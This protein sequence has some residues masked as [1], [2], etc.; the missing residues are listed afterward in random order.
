MK[1]IL[2]LLVLLV[3]FMSFVS[4]ELSDGLVAYYDLEESSGVAIDS[5]LGIHNGTVT[6]FTRQVDGILNNGYSDNGMDGLINITYHSDLNFTKNFSVSFWANYSVS[7]ANI[8]TFNHDDPNDDSLFFILFNESTRKDTMVQM[9]ESDN[10]A[11]TAWGGTATLGSW[12]HYVVSLNGSHVLIYNNNVLVNKTVYDGT[13]KSASTNWLIG[14]IATGSHINGSIDE[15][16]FWNRSLNTS[17]INELYNSGNALNPLKDLAITLNYPESSDT[18]NLNTILFNAT[19]TPTGNIFLTNA[20]FYVWYENGTL[21]NK[22]FRKTS[23]ASANYSL[24]NINNILIGEYK[25]NILG[26]GNDSS[27]T[28]CK[29]FNSNYSFDVGY[30]FN[31]EFHNSSVVEFQAN[32]FTLNVSLMSGLV[33]SDGYLRYNNTRKLATKRNIGSN[34]IYTVEIFPPDVSGY[35]NKSFIWELE[36][37]EGNG[38][39]IFNATSGNQTIN[40]LEI[41]NCT[42]QNN[43]L[44]NLTLKDEETLTKLT[45]PAYNLTIEVETLV[46]SN[47]EG[48]IQNYSYGFS[49]INPAQICVSNDTIASGLRLDTLIRYTATDYVVEFYNIQNTTLSS[50]NFPQNIDLLPLLTTDSQ[51]F[52]VTFKDDSFLPVEDALI[53][54]TRKYVDDGIFRT[55]EAPLTDS[56][57]HALVHLVLGDVVYTIQVSRYGDLLAIFDNIVPFCEDATTGN[58]QLN[59]NTFVSGFEVEDLQ[60]NNNLTWY[61]DVDYNSRRISTIFNVL[62]GATA[63]VSIN[64]TLFDNRGNNTVCSDSLTSSAGTLICDIPASWGNATFKI[65]LF[66]DG[67]FVAS[68]LIKLEESI[69][70]IFG[71]EGKYTTIIFALLLFITLPLLFITSTIG[72]VLGAMLGIIFA[73][74]LNLYTATGIFGTAATALWF[75]LAGAI[76]IWRIATRNDGV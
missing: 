25:W 5:S 17:E 72:I 46:L 76:L 43:L 45:S 48:I 67:D 58:C 36:L 55:V 37:N 63:T 1:K 70:D 54:V 22:S 2:L 50:S 69:D 74:L 52:L 60:T 53:T 59:L 41:D 29:L 38:I 44:L 62:G 61:F 57:G 6:G 68:E 42:S 7:Q 15:I 12:M 4:A 20:T 27:I 26:C 19:L 8:R 65:D 24:L 18:I 51:E 71:P 13:I 3:G 16:G 56:D 47:S 9:R 40:V 14:G 32:I 10:T 49:N 30:V 39:E 33:S 73:I 28:K 66:K 34:T 21:Y 23:G 31:N 75:L 35:I 11:I 64:G